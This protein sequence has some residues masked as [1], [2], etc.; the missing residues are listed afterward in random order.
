MAENRDRSIDAWKVRTGDS[1]KL[2][3]QNTLIED[4]ACVPLKDQKYWDLIIVFKKSNFEAN[5]GKR[6]TLKSSS[7]AHIII[8]SNK[9]PRS[10]RK[11][12]IDS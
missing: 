10:L 7:S 1:Q 12:S 5:C 8:A 11:D 6:R 4:L 3:Y 2:K 9:N